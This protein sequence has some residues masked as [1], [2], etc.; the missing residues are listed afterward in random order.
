M[1]TLGVIKWNQHNFKVETIWS[2]AYYWSWRTMETTSWTDHFRDEEVLQRIKDKR[3]ILHTVSRR[4]ANW[5]G[6]ILGSNSFLRY[7]TE[8]KT[9]GT[10]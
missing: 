6:H 7:I 8:R 3:N 5:N 4:K 2:T 10:G 1:T 9:E